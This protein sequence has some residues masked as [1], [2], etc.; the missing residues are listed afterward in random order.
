MSRRGDGSIG[1]MTP[2]SRY[3][4][5]FFAALLCVPVLARAAELDKGVFRISLRG[6][7]MGRE[8]FFID[9][10]SDSIV[11]QST[12]HMIVLT[13]AGD[14]SLDKSISLQVDPFDLNLRHYESTQKLAGSKVTRGLVMSDTSFASYRE[15][16][17]FGSG[18]VL[19]RPPGRIF[20]HDPDV[21]VLFDVIAR[22]LHTQTFDSR[23]IT[24]MVLGARDT[25]LEITATKLGVAP[26][27]WGA[28]TLQANKL[29]LA[30]GT[31][32]LLLWCDDRGRLLLFEDPASGLRVER[33]APAVKAR[34]RAS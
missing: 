26:L 12:V 34:K 10:Y 22:N 28:R 8:N 17:G 7:A 16:N 20:L 30:D 27:R 21:Y 18:D 1:L 32:R 4:A 15:E 9:Q 19:V 33:V 14:D 2:R 29:M 31:N 13:E 6:R 5:L 23:P 24:L 3:L 25:T 11:V